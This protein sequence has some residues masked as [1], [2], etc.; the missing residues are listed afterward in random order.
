LGTFAASIRQFCTIDWPFLHSPFAD[1]DKWGV[2]KYLI[3]SVL[4]GPHLPFLAFPSVK[5]GLSIDKIKDKKKQEKRK[6]KE[7]KE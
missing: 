3:T 1:F 2:F 6:R 5:I 7:P 4:S